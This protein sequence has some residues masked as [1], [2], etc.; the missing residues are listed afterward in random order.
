MV[1]NGIPVFWITF[2]SA[3]LQYSLVICLASIELELSSKIRSTFQR[4]TTTINL[5]AIA[6][7]F[8]IICDI[9]FIF[10]FDVDKTAGGLFG[11]I[12]NC[13]AIVETNGHGMLPLYYL[14]WLKEISHLV[15]L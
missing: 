1:A 11:P 10:L 9:I 7:F 14:V 5:I 6:K 2:N 8:H 15:T 3:N 12:S 13:F 4:K